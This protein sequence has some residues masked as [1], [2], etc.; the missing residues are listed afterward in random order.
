MAVLR[1]PD[2]PVAKPDREKSPDETGKGGRIGKHKQLSF[3]IKLEP[4]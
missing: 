2:H 3:L 4:T 1:V